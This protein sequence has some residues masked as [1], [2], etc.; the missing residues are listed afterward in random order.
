[1]YH[2]LTYLEHCLH[3]TVGRAFDLL[4][5]AIPKDMQ[6]HAG[7]GGVWVAWCGVAGAFDDEDATCLALKLPPVSTVGLCMPSWGTKRG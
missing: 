4:F 5:P 6:G 1:M 2:T 3:G 7:G